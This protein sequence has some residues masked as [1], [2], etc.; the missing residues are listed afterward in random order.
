M[1][2][3][4]KTSAIWRNERVRMQKVKG[5]LTGRRGMAASLTMSS[6]VKNVLEEKQRK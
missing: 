6:A 2:A 1:Q 3:K 5:P 4:T